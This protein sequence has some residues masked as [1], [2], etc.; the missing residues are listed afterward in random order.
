MVSKTESATYTH[1]HH[2]S[3]IRSHGWR[4][5]VNSVSY[6]L[7]HLKPDMKILDIG[8]GP[9]TIT[10]DLASYV[11]E[12]HV[13]GLEY[14]GEVILGQARTLA[15]ERG[16]KNIDFVSG[17]ANA[18]EYA[19]G[20]FDVVMCHQ[21]LQH[22]G[23]PVGILK[24][25]KRV[26]KSGGIVAAREADYGAFLWY[27]Q[28]DGLD[29]W[30]SLYGKIARHNGGE[31]DAGRVLHVW[32]KQAGFADIKC[33]SSNWCYSSKD[34][35]KWWAGSWVERSVASSF[36]K[37]AL[38]GKLATTEDLERVSNAW[39]AWGAHEDAWISI[40]SAEV[41]CRKE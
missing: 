20:S 5:A 27:P 17:D 14:V 35:I 2:P 7:P 31:P 30:Q 1:G 24:E 11:P 29:E 26:T 18:L 36:A 34:E 23:D 32:A 12:G 9:G 10:V 6:L 16:V 28:N 8:C 19:D 13:T 40:L 39:R 15:Q 4:T 3:V 37:T 38:D 25:M 21:V 41:I 22:V 33:S